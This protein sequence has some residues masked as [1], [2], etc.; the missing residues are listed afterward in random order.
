MQQA[1]QIILL[2]KLPVCLV[3]TVCR[4]IIIGKVMGCLSV[5]SWVVAY[6]L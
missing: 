4:R 1:A 5:R 2:F 3:R 6:D